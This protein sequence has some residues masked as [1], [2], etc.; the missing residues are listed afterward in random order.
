MPL[1][2]LRGD[3]KLAE[4][5]LQHLM[6]EYQQCHAAQRKTGVLVLA[7]WLV[8]LFRPGYT[9]E[10]MMSD[11]VDILGTSG[12]V[13]LGELA[14]RSSESPRELVATL[15][16]LKSQGL[17]QITGRHSVDLSNLSEEEITTDSDTLIGVTRRAFATG[18]F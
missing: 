5:P 9:G 16:E 3:D 10:R 7:A 13:A 1:E 11:V 14:L 2:R 4:L 8:K 17:V 12:P 15:L 6:Q 18:G